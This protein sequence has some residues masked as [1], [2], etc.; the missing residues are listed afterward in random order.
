MAK[1]TPGASNNSYKKKGSIIGLEQGKI[2]PQAIELEEAV[3][4][5]LMIDKNA[6]NEV[7]DILESECFYN[8]A[9]RE[10]YS[11]IKTLFTESQPID[12][13]TVSTMLRKN[14]KLEI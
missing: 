5:A 8:D 3:L 2:P 14:E 6:L 1:V 13:L 4:G 10:I 12:I 11:A 9:H 7:I